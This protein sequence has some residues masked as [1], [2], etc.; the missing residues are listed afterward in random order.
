VTAKFDAKRARE[1]MWVTHQNLARAKGGRP[2]YQ[3]KPRKG[4]PAP[5]K[6]T[7]AQAPAVTEAS[8]VEVSGE[9]AK[10]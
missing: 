3:P 6:K 7:A 10:S 5:V 4:P 9:T 8:S 2:L 1:N